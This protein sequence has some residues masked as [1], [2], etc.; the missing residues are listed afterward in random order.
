MEFPLLIV[1]Y[2]AIAWL[3][4]H[5]AKKKGFSWAKYFWINLL[6]GFVGW[7]ITFFM[8]RSD[9]KKAGGQTAIPNLVSSIVNTSPKSSSPPANALLVE[10]PGYFSHQVVGESFNMPAIRSLAQSRGGPGEHAVRAVLEAEPGNKFDA[11]AIKVTIDGTKVG[12]IAKTDTELYHPLLAHVA[13]S[14]KTLMCNARLFYGKGYDDDFVGSI[15]LDLPFD[16]ALAVPAN[17]VPAGAA[18]WPTGAKIQVS[19]AP[20]AT[21]TMMEVLSHSYQDGKV[22]V[23]CELRAALDDKGNPAVD[24]SV[25]GSPVGRL[26]PASAKKFQPVLTKL[27]STPCYASGVAA[28]NTLAVDLHLRM[29]KPEELSQEEIGAL[30]VAS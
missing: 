2:G 11:R 13:K 22:F 8:W 26:S 23:H 10:G 5:Q 25:M 20:D 4:A 12:H 9:N 19:L 7:I 18:L 3:I 28:G 21:L 17:A 27:G 6:L 24:V 15:T 29:K 30:G 14:G 1:F 16:L